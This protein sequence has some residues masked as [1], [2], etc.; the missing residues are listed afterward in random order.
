MYDLRLAM[1]DLRLAMYDLR[2]AMYD[3]RLKPEY[4]AQ[5]LLS[6]HPE[7]RDLHKPGYTLTTCDV[8]LTIKKIC[9]VIL[10]NLLVC[11]SLLT[12]FNLRQ[13]RV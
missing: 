3:L 12:N 8:G 5:P 7:N 9:I 1:Y 2:L 13:N 11:Q 6:C 10:T 4:N